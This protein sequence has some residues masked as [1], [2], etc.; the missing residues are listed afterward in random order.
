MSEHEPDATVE[1]ELD[2]E[3]HRFP[4]PAGTRLLDLL[5]QHGLDAPF[6]C[7]EGAC[8]ACACVLEEGRV[9]LVNNE[10][11]EQEDFDEG[12]TLACQAVAR[13]D[14]VSVTYY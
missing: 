13:S 2:G 11:L 5:L 3:K 9:E 12:Y 1:V 7:R 6:S 4:W 8:S 14:E 10:V